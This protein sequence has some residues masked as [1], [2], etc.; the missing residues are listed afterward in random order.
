MIDF[1]IEVKYFN[2]LCEKKVV[3]IEVVTIIIVVI[4]NP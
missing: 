2:S 3:E 4:L 1:K